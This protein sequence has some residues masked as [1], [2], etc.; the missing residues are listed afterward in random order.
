[1]E[2]LSG[3]KYGRLTVVKFSHYANN[4]KQYWECICNCGR[5][6]TVEKHRLISGNTKS[7][8]CLSEENVR[9]VNKTHGMSRTRIY[10]IWNAMCQRCNNKNARNYERYGGRGIN[11]CKE[12]LKFEYFIIGQ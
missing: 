9:N 11:V 6:K 10:N 8:G 5:N 3:N 1:M 2:D 4:Y 12:W 7:C